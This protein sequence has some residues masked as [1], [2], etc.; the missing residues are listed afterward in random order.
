MAAERAIDPDACR[1]LVALVVE[2]ERGIRHHP[3]DGRSW[4]ALRR[5]VCPGE[6]VEAGALPERIAGAVRA[7]LGV[8]RDPEVGR[9]APRTAAVLRVLV[10]ELRA[11]ASA[12]AHPCDPTRPLHA[13]ERAE[14]VFR[15]RVA[16]GDALACAKRLRA[17][18]AAVAGFLGASAYETGLATAACLRWFVDGHDDA[19]WCR[20]ARV[21]L[22]AVDAAVRAWAQRRRKRRRAGAGPDGPAMSV[23]ATDT[24]LDGLIR[25]VTREHADSVRLLHP[26]QRRF[27]EA[28]RILGAATTDDARDALSFVLC[29]M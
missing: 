29:G 19:A 15:E 4:R 25:A 16:A 5:A 1:L 13:A 14:V 20:D 27:T 11:T 10:R 28:L 7:L 21:L 22:D 6:D 3:P 17:D 18:P 12:L 26:P 24:E 9:R 8:T 23:N 2:R